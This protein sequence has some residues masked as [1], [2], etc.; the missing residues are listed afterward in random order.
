[1]YSRKSVRPRMEPWRTPALTGYSCADLPSRNTRSCLLLGKEEIRP[2]IWHEITFVK[3]ID[4]SNPVKSL[5]YTKCYSSSSP[6][7]LIA[8]AIPSD[9]TARRST[10]DREDIKPYWKLEKRPPFSR[11]STILLFISFWKTSNHRKKTNRVVVFRC[12]PFIN[13]LKY[14]DHQWN[15]QMKPSKN[16]ENKTP[17]GT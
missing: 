11:W 4:M 1:M 12:R 3:K 17:S 9:A 8:L 5:G 6:G 13:I 16:L 10:V 15:L 7:L 2:N 14:R